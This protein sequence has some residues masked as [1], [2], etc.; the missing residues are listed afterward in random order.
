LSGRPSL[1]SH[2]AAPLD[3]ALPIHPLHQLEASS[4]Y[5]RPPLQLDAGK[6]PTSE[7]V[8]SSARKEKLVAFIFPHQPVA[9]GVPHPHM[10]A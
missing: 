6:L 10:P 8:A 4:A 7:L 1:S 9:D 2:P 5:I 3:T